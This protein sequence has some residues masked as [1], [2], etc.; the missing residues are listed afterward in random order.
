MSVQVIK[1]DGSRETFKVAKLKKSLERA[2]AEREEIKH[3]IEH[4]EAELHD[5]MKTQEIY[6]H[7]FALLRQSE[8]PVA[9]RYSLRRALFGLGP[10]GFP[11]EAYLA[12]LFAARGYTT[13]TGV[14]IQGKC[15]EHEIDVAAYNDDHSFVVEAKFHTRPGI[16]S[17]L[18][19]AMYSY[20]RLLDLQEQKICRA[21]VCGI[22]EFWVVTNTK[23]TSSARKYAS[24]VGLTLLGWDYPKGENLH[25]LISE[26]GL[27]PV[28]VLQSLSASQKQALIKRNIIVC[29]DIYAHARSLRHLHLS[30][31][32]TE[33]VLSE[34]RQLC[35][36][37]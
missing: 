34:A 13:D 3:I 9:A 1:A 18:Q 30:T 6:R 22:T 8:V 5:G 31:R 12:R 7:A 14:M 2:G 17:D 32:K 16:K 20:A 35:H 4:I 10:T 36:K 15:A 37:P 19:V 25:N 26:T 29:S 27:Y 28:T 23:F 11:F 21:D 24:C 33:A